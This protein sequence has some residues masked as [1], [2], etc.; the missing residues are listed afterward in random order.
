MQNLINC[1]RQEIYEVTKSLAVRTGPP[2][3]LFPSF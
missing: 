2:K 1:V 3:G